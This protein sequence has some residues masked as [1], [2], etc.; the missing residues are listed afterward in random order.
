[1]SIFLFLDLS[2]VG[3]C[4]SLS[5]IGKTGKVINLAVMDSNILVD[6]E[7]LPS[8]RKS[9]ILENSGK[10]HLNNFTFMPNEKQAFVRKRTELSKKK[11]IHMAYKYAKKFVKTIDPLNTF[12]EKDV[13]LILSEFSKGGFK[14]G[15]GPC[16]GCATAAILISLALQKPIYQNVAIS[17]CISQDGK[18]GPVD[19]ID[20]KVKAA[21]SAGLKTVILPKENQRDFEEI[22]PEIRNNI[23]VVYAETFQDVYDVAFD[24]TKEDSES[25]PKFIRFLKQIRSHLWLPQ[26][27]LCPI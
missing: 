13:E 5:G 12:L 21:V 15:I 25:S 14:F 3:I 11:S 10:I 4:K 2:A 19:A 26:I 16:R 7:I 27:S 17:E 1:M 24:H 6:Q 8:L 18:I 22:P 23:K 20:K 9:L